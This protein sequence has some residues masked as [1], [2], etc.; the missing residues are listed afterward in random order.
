VD[1]IALY[2][3]FL[4]PPLLF[5]LAVQWWLKQ[6]F[7]RNAAVPTG[8]GLTGAEVARTILDRNGLHD[9]PI[10]RAAGG[11][12]SDHYDP[13]KREVFLSESVHDSPSVAATAVAAHEVG[14][15]IQHAKAY[16][17]MQIRSAIFPVVAFA[18][19]FWMIL[20][21]GGALLG[22]IG[23]IQIALVLYA[24]A[25]LFHF[26]TL[27]VEFNASTRAAGQLRELGLATAGV[28]QQGVRKVLS[29][30]A[31]TYVAGA[32]AALT[33]L[34]YFALVFLGDQE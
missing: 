5:G 4:V 13:R 10:G 14:H 12:L 23:L 28:E 26:V 22:A 21:I 29:A 1:G 17:P 11:P 6:T 8:S 20:L 30:A 7:A 34:L 16:T 15:A 2:L 9:V 31:L 18:S 3:V 24:A 19:S 25:V 32:L 33:Q 27:P